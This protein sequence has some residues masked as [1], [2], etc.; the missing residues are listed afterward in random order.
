MKVVVNECE[1]LVGIC[2]QIEKFK[3][4]GLN[5]IGFNGIGKGV[6]KAESDVSGSLNDGLQNLSDAIIFD[7]E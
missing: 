3:C 2:L 7:G 4:E 6:L 5:I 1:F